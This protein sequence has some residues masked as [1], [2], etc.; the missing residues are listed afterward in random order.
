MS[1]GHIN[2]VN[3]SVKYLTENY[4]RL[5]FIRILKLGDMKCKNMH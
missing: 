2:H 5:F 1:R 4:K 3:N